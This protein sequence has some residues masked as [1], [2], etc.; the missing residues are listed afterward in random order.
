MTQLQLSRREILG[1]GA[2]LA[3]IMGLG[4][5]AIPQVAEALESIAAGAV[6]VLWLQAQTCSGC[7]V[8]VLNSDAPGPAVLLT[9]HIALRFHQ[10]LSAV[11]GEHAIETINRTIDEGA[12]LLVVEGAVPAGMPEAC[13]I[14]HEPVAGQIARAAARARAVI[15]QGTC[16]VFGGIPAAENNPTGAVS[17]CSFL[18]GKGITTPVVSLPG[19]PPHPDWLVGTLVHL[20]R[21]GIPKLDAEGR[22]AMFYGRLLHD[23]CPRFADYERENF[24]RKFSD[25][26]CLFKLGCMGPN[27]HADCTLRNWNSGVNC[28]IKAGA[29]CIGCASREFAAKA[30]FPMFRNGRSEGTSIVQNEQ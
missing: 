21:F 11:S 8:T 17:L 3:A 13:V 28:C 20:L 4:T 23:Q 22:P 24:A 29:P 2:R 10:T 6:P 18:K 25:A 7:S 16:A 27:T 15:A 5:A 14:G 19:C 9:R 30:C 12:Y 1:L 26:G